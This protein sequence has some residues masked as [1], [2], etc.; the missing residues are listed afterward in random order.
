[1]RGHQSADTPN[2]VGQVGITLEKR[3]GRLDHQAAEADPELAAEWM[4]ESPQ[5]EMEA[6]LR[7]LNRPLDGRTAAEYLKPDG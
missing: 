2:N 4:K 7:R 3:R 5:L 1:M 6:V